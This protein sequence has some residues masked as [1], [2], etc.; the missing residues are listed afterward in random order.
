MGVKKRSP[1]R[2]V[3]GRTA[4]PKEVSRRQKKLREEKNWQMKAK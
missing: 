3:E 1:N 4:F 2:G